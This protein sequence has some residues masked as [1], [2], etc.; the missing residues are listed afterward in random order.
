MFSKEQLIENA[1]KRL[2]AKN[3]EIQNALGFKIDIDTLTAIKEKITTQKFYEVKPSDYMP[4]VVGKHAFSESILTYKDY[5]LGGDFEEG[6]LDGNSNYSKLA[7][8]DTAIDGVTVPIK[9][10]AKK[11]T[12]NILELKKASTSG[13]WSLIEAK[14]KSRFKNWQLGIQKVSFLGLLSNTGIKGMLTQADVTANTAVITKNISDM[15]ATEFQAFLKAVLAAYYTNSD[16]TVLPDSFVIPTDDYLGLGTAVDETFNMKS[17]LQRLKESFA[18]IT[19]NP[20]FMIKPLAYAQKERNSDFLGAGSGL[21]RYT[22]Y[23]SQDEESLR[24]DI[25]I[26]YTPTI[27]DTFDGFS[28]QSVAYGQFTGSK[29]YRPKEMIY[30]DHSA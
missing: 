7:A 12:F 21:N 13:N 28:Y 16:N 29:A 19:Q 25:P 27:Q 6:I 9:D 11:H 8:T 14:E 24:M 20:N 23:R 5:S 4:V 1:I 30:F 22:L 2:K 17:R 26:D 10:W 3:E 15:T 18:E